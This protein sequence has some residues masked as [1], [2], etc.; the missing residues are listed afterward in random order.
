MA[1]LGSRYDTASK[2]LAFTGDRARDDMSVN[3]IHRALF[4]YRRS[5]YSQPDELIQHCGDRLKDLTIVPTAMGYPGNDSSSDA[6]RTAQR[7]LTSAR[8]AI[9]PVMK[10]GPSAPQRSTSES[11]RALL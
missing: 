6:S 10:T 2:P 9:E 5:N 8:V 7:E 3:Y 11:A 1:E 4:D